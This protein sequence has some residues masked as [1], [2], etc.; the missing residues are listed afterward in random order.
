MD[1]KDIAD[2]FIAATGKIEF[3]WNFYT[4]T[5]LAL[6]G[7]LVSTRKVLGPGL[8]SLITVGYLVFVLMN[9][10]GLWGSYTFA[11]ALR[12]DLL[13]AASA[14]PDILGNTQAVLSERSFASQRILALMIHTILGVFVLSV[15][16]FGRFG[17]SA[18]DTGN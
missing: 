14:A 2:L 6:I 10:L 11:E 9:I 4:L 16:W 5:L 15:I 18:S 13:I 1:I 3:Y 17:E 12:E 8:K 7:W